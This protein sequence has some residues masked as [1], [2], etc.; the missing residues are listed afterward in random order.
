MVKRVAGACRARSY[1]SQV[2]VTL[3][4]SC[5]E[6]TRNYS[7][8]ERASVW[9]ALLHVVVAGVSRLLYLRLDIES[10]MLRVSREPAGQHESYHGRISGCDS[11]LS[12]KFQR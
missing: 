4:H 7:E 12:Y 9:I 1:F 10:Y 8:R 2:D 11:V 6:D 3:V 5:T